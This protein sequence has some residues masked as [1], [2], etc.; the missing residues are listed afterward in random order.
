MKIEKHI[1]AKDEHEA[2]LIVLYLW[3][4]LQNEELYNW[5]DCYLMMTLKTSACYT[6][7]M[8]CCDERETSPFFLVK[9]KINFTEIEISFLD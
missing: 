1:E 2:N 4:Y 3:V 7:E 5:K 9:Y 6:Q 8:Y